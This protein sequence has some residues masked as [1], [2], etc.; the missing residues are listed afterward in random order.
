M[1]Q[2]KILSITIP[3]IFGG[4]AYVNTGSLHDVKNTLNSKEDNNSKGGQGTE[5]QANLIA[6][7][8]AIAVKRFANNTPLAIA[9]LIAGRI[10]GK[11]LAE[12]QKHYKGKELGLLMKIESVH[13]EEENLINRNKILD[14][15]I[16][17]LNSKIK[18]LKN[19]KNLDNNKK[20]LLYKEIN[21]KIEEKKKSLNALLKKNKDMKIKI[22]KSEAKIYQY[23]YKSK[24]KKA[25]QKDLGIMKRASIE[26][27]QNINS[28]IRELDKLKRKIA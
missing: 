22:R 6:G 8:S 12:M 21:I 10:T 2:V 25:L 26:L 13:A 7:F 3:L 15:E 18:N 24:D 5:T 20:D 28:K 23:N 16:K 4:C 14:I 27:R 19:Q 17:E 11:K 1:K 9:T